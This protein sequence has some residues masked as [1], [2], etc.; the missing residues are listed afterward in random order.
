MQPKSPIPGPHSLPN[1]AA[2]SSQAQPSPNPQQQQQEYSCI[3]CKQ[4]KVRCDRAKPCSGCVR[5]GV[6]CEP[7]VRQP[8]KRRK[9]NGTSRDRDAA[10]TARDVDGVSR[11]LEGRRPLAA[12]E[13][14]R[15]ERQQ[16]PT[17]GQYVQSTVPLSRLSKT[18]SSSPLTYTLSV[19]TD[20]TH[21]SLWLGL[22][23]EVKI[24]ILL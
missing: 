8:Y 16:V 15:P 21:R 2:A 1:T 13:E 18:L 14:P 20:K 7:G 10:A 4:R 11:I 23:E 17:F 22:N 12:Q 6:T 19:F 3:L 9:R 24:P 5:A